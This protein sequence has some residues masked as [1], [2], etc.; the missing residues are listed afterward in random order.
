MVKKIFKFVSH[1]SREPVQESV[2]DQEL[3]VRV[4]AGDRSA[5]KILVER[6]QTR[7]FGLVFQI[8]RNREDSED[9]VQEAF[10]KAYLSIDSFE[11]NSSF[12]TWFY[13]IAVNMAIDLKRKQKRSIQAVSSINEEA[14]QGDAIERQVDYARIN[15]P[16]TPIEAVLRTEQRAVFQRALQELSSEHRAV[17]SMRELEELRYDEIAD[18]LGVSQGTVMSRLHYARKRLKQLLDGGMNIKGPKTSN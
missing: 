4:K 10:V 12:F 2:S 5:Y 17:I 3:V 9:V 18:V 13:R 1:R 11:G 15:A 14:G 8:I 7:A 16:E 6:Y